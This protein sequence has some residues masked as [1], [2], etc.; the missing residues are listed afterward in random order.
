MT[1]RRMRLH[2]GRS[3]GSL[4]GAACGCA[5]VEGWRVAHWPTAGVAAAGTA[6]GAVAAHCLE[7]MGAIRLC[8]PEP[9]ESG[10]GGALPGSVGPAQH[11]WCGLGV[12]GP[13]RGGLV[14]PRQG[15]CASTA[16]VLCLHRG[17]CLLQHLCSAV[18]LQPL[19]AVMPQS[20]HQSGGYWGLQSLCCS[21]C[22]T[23][24]WQHVRML[25]SLQERPS[26]VT[27]QGTIGACSPCVAAWLLQ[28]LCSAVVL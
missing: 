12:R 22:T 15:S 9:H 2:R 23:A 5:G 1:Q 28:H 11:S 4:W 26:P 8:A 24:R 20:R 27:N 7:R 6:Q 14:P 13:Q 17:V 18:M 25:Q 19:A 21:L 10:R 3:V 16:E